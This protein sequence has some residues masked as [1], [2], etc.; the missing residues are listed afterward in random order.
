M[1]YRLND[2]WGFRATHDFNAQEG[3]LQ[4]Q[5]YTI[6][7]DMRSWTGALTFRV[8]DNG[9]G[10]PRDYTVAFTFSLKANPRYHLGDDTV[11]PYSLVGE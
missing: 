4:Q 3:R 10:Q 2:N 9:N 7:R 11:Q 5:F 6:Y 8:I 1:F